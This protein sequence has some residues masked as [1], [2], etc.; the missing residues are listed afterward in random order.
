MST[1]HV[2]TAEVNGSLKTALVDKD[3]YGDCPIEDF[4]VHDAADVTDH[5][6]VEIDGPAEHMLPD[7]IVES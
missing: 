1:Y 3:A 6:T 2:L 5:G 7:T 4:F